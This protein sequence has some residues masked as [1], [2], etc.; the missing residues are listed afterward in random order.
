MGVSLGCGHIVLSLCVSV[1]SENGED[2]I[3]EFEMIARAMAVTIDPRNEHLIR[4]IRDGKILSEMNRD[5]T[6]NNTAEVLPSS[7]A[8]HVRPPNV[9]WDFCAEP[10]INVF[11][12]DLFFSAHVDDMSVQSASL[13]VHNSGF[14]MTEPHERFSAVDSEKTMR[15]LDR[16]IVPRI[17]CL[18]AV[19]C[20]V[21]PR[22]Q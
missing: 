9:F 11:G 18:L 16:S 22:A 8:F 3:V 17:L 20:G 1:E 14:I 6:P 15:H 19:R 12:E 10:W 13:R 4:F 21:A 2:N 7:A 5:S